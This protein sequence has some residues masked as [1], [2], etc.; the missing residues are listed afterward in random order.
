LRLKAFQANSGRGK[1]LFLEGLQLKVIIVHTLLL[2]IPLIDV[3]STVSTKNWF[4]HVFLTSK[5]IMWSGSDDE[6]E[7]IFYKCIKCP[8]QT[9]TAAEKDEHRAKHRHDRLARRSKKRHVQYVASIKSTTF[10]FY[11]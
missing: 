3:L 1:S 6:V 8:G 5:R 9:F 10:N 2:T 11:V 7:E 4:I